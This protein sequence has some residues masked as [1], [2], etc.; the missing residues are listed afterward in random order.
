MKMTNEQKQKQEALNA[1]SPC[2]NCGHGKRWHVTDADH[3][4]YGDCEHPMGE[5]L[6]R[7]PGYVKA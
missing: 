3:Q 4:R 7:C 1:K 2:A 6:C 5:G